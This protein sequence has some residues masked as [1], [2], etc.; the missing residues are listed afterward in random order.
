MDIL[1]YIENEAEENHAIEALKVDVFEK[2]N[3]IFLWVVLVVTLLKSSGH[4]KSLKW[5]RRKLNL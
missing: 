2:S 5:L 1:R 3:G 4:G